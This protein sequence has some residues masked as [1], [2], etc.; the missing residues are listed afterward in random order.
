MGVAGTGINFR[1][2]SKRPT[3]NRKK[4]SMMGKK[5]VGIYFCTTKLLI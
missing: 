4:D 5:Y 2:A 3:E 1:S